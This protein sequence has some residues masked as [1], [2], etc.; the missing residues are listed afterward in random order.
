MLANFLVTVFSLADAACAQ[1]SESLLVVRPTVCGLK[2]GTQVGK[3]RM[4][5][6]AIKGFFDEPG[7]GIKSNPGV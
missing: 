7:Q 1:K 4:R 6:I 3:Q 5:R 2:Q